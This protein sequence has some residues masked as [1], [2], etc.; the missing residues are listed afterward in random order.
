MK[1]YKMLQPEAVI[2]YIDVYWSYYYSFEKDYQRILATNQ[3]KERNLELTKLYLSVCSEIE[4][5]LKTI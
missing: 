1:N 3:P 4:V 5:M 2:Q